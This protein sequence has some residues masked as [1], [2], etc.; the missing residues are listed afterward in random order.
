MQFTKRE[1][2]LSRAL[3][4]LA[5]AVVL[6][7]VCAVIGPFGTYQDLGTGARY[8]YW[9]GLVLFGAVSIVIAAHAL[10]ALRIKMRQSVRIAVITL[11]S[12]V[13]TTFAVGWAESLTRLSKPIPLEVIPR[14]YGSVALIQ[15]LIV[16]FLMRQR[17][18]AH[19][20]LLTTPPAEAQ[21]EMPVQPEAPP[22]GIRP[23]P[24]MARIP[25]HLG[26]ELLAL[27]AEDHYLR[28]ITPAGSDLILMRLGDAL[29]ELDESTGLQVHRSWWV[30]HDAVRTIRRDGAKL[31]LVLSDGLEVPV[32]R[33]YSAAVRT[34]EW[35]ALGPA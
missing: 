27:G 13:P 15:L 28:V 34:A 5:A 7:A 18:S 22:A 32:S 33:T 10:A 21:P 23:Q 14:L 26:K 17:P 11:A 12:A 16:L 9:I 30:A 29:K 20:L 24:F 4:Q 25:S 6:G 19:S 31:T 3:F 8:A 2:D 1:F 35:P